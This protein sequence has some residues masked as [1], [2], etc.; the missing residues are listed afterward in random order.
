[1]HLPRSD[2][3]F[4][5]AESAWHRRCSDNSRHKTKGNFMK[6]KILKSFLLAGT[7]GIAAS[8]INS[9]YAAASMSTTTSTTSTSRSI[10]KNPAVVDIRQSIISEQTQFLEQ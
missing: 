4:R 10:N 1:M 7:L 6:M 5:K 9:T 2:D 3:T 8:T